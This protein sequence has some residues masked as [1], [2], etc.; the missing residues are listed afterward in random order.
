MKF[1]DKLIIGIVCLVVG[2]FATIQ[3]RSVQD[4]Y[5][6]GLIPSKRSDQLI[7]ELNKLRLDKTSLSEEL[8]LR[9]QE[10]ADIT[11]NASNDNALI[12]NLQN[13]VNRYKNILGLTDV[14]GEGVII[15]IDNPLEISE[16]GEIINI[17]DEYHYLLMFVNELNAAGAEA[18]SINNERFVAT[19]EM[20]T[21][22]DAININGRLY[23]SPFIVKAIGNNIVLNGA[24]NQRFGIVTLLR[25][26][27]YQVDTSQV[28]SVKIAKYNGVINWQY[29]KPME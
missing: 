21:A 7:E 1:R 17:V 5:L 24:I 20:R 15:G 8:A 4:D 22:G 3:Y 29:A 23:K 18:I 26:R 11:Q 28:D 19:T 2:F 10:L 6:M 16:S 12:K 9:E 14:E 13:Q 27:G 25:D